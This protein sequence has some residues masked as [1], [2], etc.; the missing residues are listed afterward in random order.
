MQN[1]DERAR[2]AVD[3]ICNVLVENTG[4]SEIAAI[5]QTCSIPIVDGESCLDVGDRI[6]HDQT[7]SSIN[8][9]Q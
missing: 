1:V 2:R 9:I 5:A 7:S 3:E 6:S 8:R 4:L